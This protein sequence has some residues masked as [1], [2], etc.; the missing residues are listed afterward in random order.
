V[1]MRDFNRWHVFLLLVTY[2]ALILQQIIHPIYHDNQ[3]NLYNR[4]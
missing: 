1:N 3:P 4:P 2:L